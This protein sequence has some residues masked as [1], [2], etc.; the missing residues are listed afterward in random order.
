M[1]I[2]NS[3]GKKVILSIWNKDHTDYSIDT[4]T[5]PTDEELVIMKLKGV[6]TTNDWADLNNERM[7]QWYAPSDYKE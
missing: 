4:I 6:I 2:V 1:N 5:Y 3:I 7:E